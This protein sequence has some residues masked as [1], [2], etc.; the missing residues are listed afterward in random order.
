MLSMALGIGVSI[1]F[2]VSLMIF[3][4]AGTQE[5]GFGVGQWLL[6]VMACIMGALYFKLQ[7][8]FQN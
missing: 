6:A 8:S 2:V 3:G 7:E 1:S 4:I 5:Q